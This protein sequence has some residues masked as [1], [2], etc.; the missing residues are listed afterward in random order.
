MKRTTLILFFGLL[1]VSFITL[2]AR[3]VQMQLVDGSVYQLQADNNRFRSVTINA[4]RGIVYDRNSRQLISNQPS[5]SVAVTEADLPEEAAAQEA[6]FAALADLLHTAPVVTA[7]P[8]KLLADAGV[9]ARVIKQL[10]ATLRIS[11]AELRALIE[12]ANKLS[13]EAPALLRGELDSAM[14]AAIRAHS[15]TDW[16]GVQVMNELQYTY[17]TRRESPIRPVTIKRNIPYETMQRVEEEHLRLP[18]VSV[19]PE[20]VR[21]Y[22]AGSFMSHI[23]GYVGPIPPD[24]YAESL[25][26]EGSGD[27]APYEKD[28][29][30]GLL[31]VEASM[32]S[33][34]RGRKGARE[35]EVNANQREVREISNQPPVPGQNVVLTIDSRLQE[36]V[37]HLLQAGIDAAHANARASGAPAIGGG[38]AIVQK[39]NTGE[40]LAMVSLPSY[41]DNLFAAGISQADFDRLN[42][43]PNLPMF[44]RAIGGGYA[45]GSTFKMI[46]AAAGLEENVIS[47]DTQIFDGGRIDVPSTYNE[48]VRTPYVCWKKD[49]HGSINILQA[50]QESCDVFFYQVAGP[51]QTDQRGQ[52]TRFYIPRDPSPHPFA[53][54]GIS[55]MDKWMVNFGI[56]APTGIELPGELGGIVPSPDWKVKHFP[57]N[58]WALGD[59]LVTA[60]GQGFNSV[61]P[62][63]LNNV[64]AAVANGGTLYQPTVIYQILN[65]DGGTVEQDFHPKVIRQSV[66]ISAANLATVREGMRLAVSDPHKGTAYK[67]NLKGVEIAGKT[68]TAE[69]GEVIDAAGHRRAHAWFTAFA[70]YQNPEIAVTVLLEAG[71]ESLEG[72][73]FAVPVARGIFK[74]YF[75]LDE[76]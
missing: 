40:V 15:D 73:T 25:P 24:Q 9:A 47:R 58:Y 13:P 34:L 28:D 60:I 7:E 54:L 35:I 6:V 38:V 59:T 26:K 4:P 32:E 14:S 31:G 5:F 27:P 74:A 63:Q 67:T 57:D 65:S 8:D 23:L 46:T 61:T 29:K 55:L 48:K 66:G 17:I 11:E 70:P 56:G 39:V 49:G 18:G 43:D 72:S 71:D 45:P 50:I 64:T 52:L 75:H 69:I 1:I 76:P 51:L 33:V 36:T 42:S 68:G 30:I 53:G 44:H 21:Q 62:L 37:T 19:L 10:A 16:P 22:A 20:P 3:L 2:G 41:D 12:D